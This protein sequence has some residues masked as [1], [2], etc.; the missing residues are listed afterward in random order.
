MHNQHSFESE[1][2]Y[3]PPEAEER[4]P[5]DPPRLTRYGT[6]EELTAGSELA[7]PT[8]DVASKGG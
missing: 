5:Y 7:S 2:E 6:L 8:G 3:S 1:P 4:K